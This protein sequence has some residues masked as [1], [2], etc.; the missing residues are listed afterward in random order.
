M[1]ELSRALDEYLSARENGGEV[2]LENLEQRVG[3]DVEEFRGLVRL[4]GSL[5]TLAALAEVDEDTPSAGEV[6]AGRYQ[7]KGLLG[8]GG[9]S[10]VFRVY[11]S[12]LKRDIALKVLDR[13]GPAWVDADI[14]LA[15]ARALAKIEHPSVVRVFDA[16]Q[17]Q[18]QTYIAMEMVVGPSLREVLGAMKS[19]VGGGAKNGHAEAA[20]TAAQGLLSTAERCR[21]VSRLAS[22]L[23]CCHESSVLH[24]DIKPEN[25]LVTPGLVP[26]LIDFGL[27]HHEFT[28]SDWDRGT[29]RGTPPYLAPEQV[30]RERTGSH[31][32]SDQFSLGVVF[33]ELLTLENPF[34]RSSQKATLEAI[35]ASVPPPLRTR[36]SELPLDVELICLHCLERDPTERYPQIS[37]LSDD[38]ERFLDHRAVSLRPPSGLR[39]AVLW[40][41]RHRDQVKSAVLAAV[42]IGFLLLVVWA[43]AAFL[44]AKRAR[45]EFLSGIRSA[46]EGL[47]EVTE[48]HAFEELLQN[49]ARSWPEAERHDRSIVGKWYGG[50]AVAAVHDLREACLERLDLVIARVNSESRSI[51]P[52]Q[53]AKP[54]M[55]FFNDW[56]YTLLAAQASAAGTDTRK[57]MIPMGVVDLPDGGT[58]EQYSNHALPALPQLITQ[59]DWARKA[60]P[61]FY[62]YTI[63]RE[64]IWLETEFQVR[65]TEP[66]WSPLLRELNPQISDRMATLDEGQLEVTGPGWVRN[67]SYDAFR[68]LSEPVTWADARTVFDPAE[69]ASSIGAWTDTESSKVELG[70]SYPAVLPWVL[71]HEYSVRV[72]ARLPTPV[73]LGVAIADERVDRAEGFRGEWTSAFFSQNEERRYWLTYPAPLRS[74][75]DPLDLGRPLRA[76]HEESYLPGVAFRVAQSVLE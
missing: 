72:G 32:S 75:E 29:L 26:K 3:E 41:R 44:S 11:D 51:K 17:H 43:A 2:D 38:L 14:L 69:L 19:M 20:M 22:A 4:V 9:H 18:D 7:V 42:G 49:I 53:R 66:P 71:A 48:A 12:R 76:D 64:G 68:T 39:Q 60:M 63:Q 46:Q 28:E 47:V 35:S 54:F 30:D 16:D 58:L 67:V 25:I 5:E 73:E 57:R 8:E 37:E 65:L 6:I 52:S 13:E 23:A 33:Y 24:R 36:K 50:G 10:R 31:A 40:L 1:D 59:E 27:A 45:T 70:D 34:V 61:G 62:R 74:L 15:E 55:A 21:F 56:V